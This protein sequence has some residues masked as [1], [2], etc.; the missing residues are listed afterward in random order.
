[1]SRNQPYKNV[2]TNY[3]CYGQHTSTTYR[4]GCSNGT[5]MTFTHPTGSSKS[6][7]SSYSSRRKYK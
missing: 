7:S 3:N 4:Y 6:Y 5:K 2:Q 1:M